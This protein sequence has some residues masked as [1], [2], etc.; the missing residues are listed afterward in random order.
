[1]S[2]RR[3]FRPGFEASLAAQ[4][5]LVVGSWV[6]LTSLNR[7]SD[8]L[9]FQVDAPRHAANGLFWKDFLLSG[10]LD[11]K[12]YTLSY[13]ARYPVIHPTAYPPFFYVLEGALFGIVGPSPFAAKYLV[14]AFG[15]VL[16]LYI[17]AWLR[18]WI[19]PETGWAGAVVPLLPGIVCWS[20]AVMLNIP[21]TA[22]GV[23]A[24]YH[25]RRFLESPAGAPF[26][27]HFYVAAAL[28]VLAIFTYYTAGVVV[29]I[30]AAWLIVMRRWDLLL[31]RWTIAAAIVC[32]IVLAPLSVVVFRNA[33]QQLAWINPPIK[34]SLHAATWL[35]YPMH[36][37][38]LF[39]TPLLAL[40][41]V[42]IVAGLAVRR[43][44]QETTLWLTAIVIVWLCFSYIY[45]REMRYVLLLTAPLVCLCAIAVF[46]L[47]D[48]MSA[49]LP[50]RRAQARF[51]ILSTALVTVLSVEASNAA[52]TPVPAVGGVRDAAEFLQ[53]AA[54]T[55]P[56]LYDGHLFGLFTFHVRASDPRFQRRVVR[57]D[58]VF[59]NGN[60]RGER[61][62]ASPEELVETLRSRGGCQWLAVEI[63][64]EADKFTRAPQLREAVKTTPFALV[65]SFPVTGHPT[66]ERID[67]YRFEAPLARSAFV[68][69]PITSLGRR[70]P[71][72]I[73]PIVS[74][75]VP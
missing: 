19:A 20:H 70:D 3:W 51:A 25:T 30:A 46:S 18:R 15:L 21:A 1:M 13:Y 23:G 4:V 8:G 52:R 14:L 9:W 61:R 5:L 44:R 35:F 55:E 63:G 32:A 42:G 38:E 59:K 66:V 62:T 65:R 60:P 67:V 50:S 26:P 24:L 68:D 69:V 10:S 45:A 73:K 40:A 71:V 12:G 17:T 2:L 64:K 47:A 27:R 58:K 56:V 39:G 36:L 37:H 48:A 72:R 57:G 41:G 29:L 43:W 53:T 54:P 6:Y 28:S 49:M 22:I 34:R 74:S 33:P 7:E 16:A 31:R 75:A 11:P